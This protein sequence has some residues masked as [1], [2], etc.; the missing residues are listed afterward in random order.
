[1]NVG[2]HSEHPYP[3]YVKSLEASRHHGRAARSRDTSSYP[4]AAHLSLWPGHE[5]AICKLNFY[6]MPARCMQAH[7][8]PYANSLYT[9]STNCKLAIRK[10]ILH[11]ARARYMRAL[12]PTR[13]ELVP[14]TDLEHLPAPIQCD[15]LAK[16]K[17]LAFN[18]SLK[19]LLLMLELGA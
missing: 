1:M 12:W 4:S 17:K 18:T 9:S 5:L 13:C 8:L 6:L 7:L 10:L 19:I 15:R 3:G 2:L 16:T 11:Q 14:P